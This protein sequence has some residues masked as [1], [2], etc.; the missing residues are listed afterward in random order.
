MGWCPV[1]NNPV[2]TSL[3]FLYSTLEADGTFMGYVNGVYTAMAPEGTTPDYCVLQPMSSTAIMTAFGKKIMTN[4][5][6]SVKIVGPQDHYA[7][8][9]NAY[10]QLVTD[11]ALVRPSSGSYGSILACYQESDIYIQE[12]VAGV[13]WLNLGGMFRIEV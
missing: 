1:A 11:I 6:Y 7:N 10:N 4:G 8:I 12:V 2:Q 3:G 9:F 5:L 13:Q